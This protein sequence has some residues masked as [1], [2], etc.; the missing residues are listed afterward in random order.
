[1]QTLSSQPDANVAGVLRD[2]RRRDT[3]QTVLARAIHLLA[4]RSKHRPDLSLQ[5]VKFTDA[6]ERELGD[7][8]FRN[9]RW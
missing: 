2:D 8:A 1:M 7:R 5:N 3:V 4:S 9:S 6:L